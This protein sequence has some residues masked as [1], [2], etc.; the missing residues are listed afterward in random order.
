MIW[1]HW[2]GPYSI[3]YYS[4]L[5]S[6]TLVF[7]EYS[8]SI[9]IQRRPVVTWNVY[10]V[11]LGRLRVLLFS[12]FETSKCEENW[13]WINLDPWKFRKIIWPVETRIIARLEAPD[14]EEAAEV[15]LLRVYR[16]KKRSICDCSCILWKRSTS[17]RFAK[18]YSG[19]QYSLR[20]A[21]IVCVL[22]VF[23]N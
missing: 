20:S 19:I 18:A 13:T 10:V 2:K 21:A 22:H 4:W 11:L 8:P 17:V 15:V 1:I 14:L 9:F 12:F 7:N 3:I 23:P 5:T 6:K 16:K